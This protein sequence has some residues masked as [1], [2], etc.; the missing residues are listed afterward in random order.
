MRRHHMVVYDQS[1]SLKSNEKISKLFRDAIDGVPYRQCADKFNQ[2]NFAKKI[3]LTVSK[4]TVCR[5]ANGRF[6]IVNKRIK[7]LCGFFDIDIYDHVDPIC[8]NEHSDSKIN[9]AI[10]EIEAEL[11]KVSNL[12]KKN[13]ALG[14]KLS[15]MIKGITDLVFAQGA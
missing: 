13:P 4:D 7:A 2:S 6:V 14:K 10:P 15:N 9:S 11:N 12:A 3:G 1:Q 5:L 8:I